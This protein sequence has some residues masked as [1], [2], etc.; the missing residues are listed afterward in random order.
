M[1]TLRKKK[2]HYY[3][4]FYD[5]KRTP[6]RKEIALRTTYKS[7]A[8]AALR[9]KEEAYAQGK[10]DPWT[11]GE[12]QRMEA[13]TVKE[14]AEAFL[15]SRSNRRPWTVR[16]YRSYL[17]QWGRRLPP[18][19]MLAAVG[20]EHV[21]PYLWET[22]LKPNS[23]RA[24]ARHLKAF[25]SWAIKA[26]HLSRNPMDAVEIPREEKKV[27]TYL[28]AEDVQRILRA[29]EADYEI[30]AAQGQ[31][32]R[33]E[34]LWLRDVI[35]V[36]VSTG[37]RR[38]EICSLRWPAVN[39][40]DRHV[41]V[42]RGHATKSHHERPVPLA[43]PAFDVLTR[44]HE[45]RASEYVFRGRRGGKLNGDY[46]SKQFKRYVRLARLPE[47][48]SFHCLRHTCASWLVMKGVP[49]RVVQEILG[50]SSV[51][52]TQRYAHLAPGIM[53]E[54]METTFGAL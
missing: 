47:D 5:P 36:A 34:I 46:V 41:I 40:T 11:P 13:M 33:G 7:V 20:P 39:L 53:R 14:A 37:L 21:R 2:G 32:Q 29:I 24:R 6:T 49:M 16:G 26:G 28:T 22:G 3:A 52:V 45:Q 10:F 50:H 23:L 31:A 48:V 1:A 51:T 27:P 15:E 12:M 43:K 38:E 17:N 30:K 25:F 35:M 44:L 4:R 9:E 54:A 8:V 19:M 42:G 18:G